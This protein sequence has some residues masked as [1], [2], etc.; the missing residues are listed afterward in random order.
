MQATVIQLLNTRVPAIPM[1]TIAEAAID[2]INRGK[3]QMTVNGFHISSGLAS[4][5]ISNKPSTGE[6]FPAPLLSPHVLSAGYQEM[7]SCTVPLVSNIGLT[8]L[9]CRSGQTF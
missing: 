8:L 6:G 1:N 4:T 9:L 3:I 7:P 2:M 5:Q